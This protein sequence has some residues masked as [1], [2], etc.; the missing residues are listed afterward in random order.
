LRYLS[1]ANAGRSAARNYGAR[2]ARG[3]WLTFL[4]S[5]DLYLPTS[6][7]AHRSARSR[8]PNVAMT[9]GGYEYIDDEGAWLGERRPWDECGLG[10]ADWLFNCLGVQG[11]VMIRR[12]WF[13]RSHG[14]DTRFN[15]AED[16]DLFLRLAQSGC[17]MG[18]TRASVFQYRQHS[19][20][21]TRNYAQHRDES[22]DALD[23][24]FQAPD[25]PL[26]IREL[27]PRAKAWVC[28]VFARRAFAFGHVESAV[29]DLQRALEMD[30]G[31]A[32]ERRPRLLEG[33]FSPE[34]VGQFGQVDMEAAVTPFLPPGLKRHAGDI[35][36]AQA[37]VQMAAFF[38]AQ[39]RG[40]RE[41]AQNYL[42]AALRRDARWLFN[43][44]V[45]AFCLRQLTGL[46][47]PAQHPS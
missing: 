7:A 4:D 44:G 26:E 15:I 21:S 42:S 14:Y 20:N 13:E 16:W 11:S 2:Q 40:A 37:R 46:A 22:L 24:V 5:D 28:V 30:P 8:S 9:L 45:L 38:R 17:P 33:L 18:W 36:R 43:R 39:R 35:R 23:R 41:Q 10:L 32:G 27:A 47:R 29:Q 31:L 6:L 19:G 25:L 1:Q 3:E 12:D 34:T